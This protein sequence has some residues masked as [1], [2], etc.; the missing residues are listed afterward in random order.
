MCAKEKVRQTWCH[1]HICRTTS[2]YHYFYHYFCNYFCNY[3]KYKLQK[4]TITLINCL[5]AWLIDLFQRMKQSGTVVWSLFSSSL[6][7][8]R[9]AHQ[10]EKHYSTIVLP[11]FY[12]CFSN[13]KTCY[14]CNKIC[15]DCNFFVIKKL[16]P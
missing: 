8:Q 10:S 1:N 2:V 15:Y 16:L 11:L 3:Y 9:E 6:E 13:N 14:V 12:H 4:L 5:I 7:L